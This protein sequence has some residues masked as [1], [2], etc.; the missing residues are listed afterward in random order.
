MN[1]KNKITIGLMILFLVYL[2]VWFSQK[3]ESLISSKSSTTEKLPAPVIQQKIKTL[4]DGRPAPVDPEAAKRGEKEKFEPDPNAILGFAKALMMPFTLVG[5]VVDQSGTPIPGAAIEWSA[6]NNPDPY[7]PGTKGT[8]M[9]DA[10]GMFVVKSHGI[11]VYVKA[12]KQGF[13]TFFSDVRKKIQGSDGGFRHGG[14]LG[15]TDLPM[16][17]E[18]NPSILVLRKMGE[19]VPL[20]HITERAMRTPKNGSPVQVN[21]E[22]RQTRSKGDL[23]VQCWTNDQS[24]NAQGH[25]DWKCVL[26]V[27]G[28]G[29][30]ER[31]ERFAFEAPAEGYQ[32]S[33]ELIPPTEKWASNIERQYFVKLSDNRYARI[34][35][36]MRTGGEHF[37]VIESFLNPTPGSRNLEYD[38]AKTIKP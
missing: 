30:I 24:K 20:V 5:K 37:F 23:K 6:N 36:R 32:E 12:S 9:T 16:G 27:P 35:F 10:N 15:N 11:G 25:Y 8:S 19:T 31:N 4:P 22:T 14:R 33:V 26:T 38:P 18:T 21:L 29:L 13:E 34:N 7:K 2:L 28:G 3:S 17:T 1:L